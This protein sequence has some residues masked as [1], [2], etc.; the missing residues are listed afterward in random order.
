MEGLAQQQKETVALPDAV[1]YARLPKKA[2]AGHSNLRRYASSNGVEFTPDNNNIIR[3]P[4][5]SSGINSFLDGAHS[6]LQLKVSADNKTTNEAQTLD[7]GVWACIQR[8][9]IL[10]R[11]SG[12]VLEDINNYNLLHNTLFKFQTDPSKLAHHNAVSG[13]AG[14]M[15]GNGADPSAAG[16]EVDYDP[17]ESRGF[18]G[19]TAASDMTLCMPLIS[20]FLSNTKG[21]YC[22]LGASGGIELE[23]SI[24]SALSCM[25]AATDV[26]YKI[27]Q[28]HFYAPVVSITGDDFSNSMAQMISVMG[29]LS[30]TGSTYENFVSNTDDADGE[31]VINIPVQCRS[32][33]AIM[34]VSRT[35]ANV[36]DADFHGLTTTLPNA[37]TAFNYRVGDNMYPPSRIQVNVAD[38]DSNNT[39]NAYNQCLLATGQLNSIHAQTLINNSQFNTD[40]WVYAIDTEAYLNETSNVSHTGLDV[41]NG[42][43]QCALEVNN[44]PAAAQ[45]V[46]TFCLKEVLYYMDSNGSFSVSR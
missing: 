34:S 33:R 29:G 18:A 46:D 27:K 43:L 38:A 16:Y 42:N 5:T 37:T 7:G 1:K 10:C 39:A 2:I 3:I 44:N 30:F 31:K 26:N 23:F 11:T 9:R 25:V 35:T 45:R 36:A 24:A 15:I 40:S 28:A 32:L 17:A 20:G 19:N 13:T 4:V 8:M 14:N 22:P 12:A 21:V 41:L 6:Y